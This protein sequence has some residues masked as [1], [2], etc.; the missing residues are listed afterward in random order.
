MITVV[1]IN[2]DL[3]RKKTKVYYDFPFYNYAPHSNFRQYIQVKLEVCEERKC[4]IQNSSTNQTLRAVCINNNK[5][6]KVTFTIRG[7]YLYN[8][9]DI[10]I[11]QGDMVPNKRLWI[12]KYAKMIRV[13]AVYVNTS[14]M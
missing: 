1:F 2:S 14:C 3:N 10:T 9:L 6:K 8:T 5:L 11:R 7:G 13:T 4:I 12:Y